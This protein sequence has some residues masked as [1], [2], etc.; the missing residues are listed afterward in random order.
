MAASALAIPLA[1]LRLSSDA[2]KYAMKILQFTRAKL[3]ER[4][5][6]RGGIRLNWRKVGDLGVARVGD[7]DNDKLLMLRK[8][9]ARK[10]P[11]Q[12]RHRDGHKAKREAKNCARKST[13]H[14]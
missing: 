14:F 9:V 8:I 11:K 5:V 7:V 2:R 6:S 3:Y 4:F 10:W 1:V 12:H 13:K